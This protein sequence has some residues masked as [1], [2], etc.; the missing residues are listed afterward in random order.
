MSR[1][2]KAI[3]TSALALA[4]GCNG[5]SDGDGSDG[6]DG[7]PTRTHTQTEQ[8]CPPDRV[9]DPSFEDGSPNMY[10]DEE[11]FLYDNVICDT[12]CIQ[13]G[14]VEPR[15]GSYMVWFGGIAET[16]VA[17]VRQSL[18]LPQGLARVRF[19]LGIDTGPLRNGDDLLEV[20]LN[21]TVVFSV[22]EAETDDYPL[23]TEIEEVVPVAAGTNVLSFEADLSGN[24]LT[25][26]FIDDVS[27]TVCADPNQPP[28]DTGDTSDDT[29]GGTSEDGTT[30]SSGATETGSTTGTDV[31]GTVTNGTATSGAT[32][33]G[34]GGATSS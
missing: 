21:D 24:H 3:V 26:F 7:N 8:I 17:W 34:T 2:N 15:T 22:T 14:G 19:W 20:Q 28:P 33:T 4:L 30:D 13:D 31:S 16:E 11:S 12:S 6:G 1:L 23:Y 32:G 18:H 9:E 5:S 10:W 25:S 29:T 27:V